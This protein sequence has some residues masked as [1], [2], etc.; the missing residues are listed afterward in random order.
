M[1]AI[2]FNGTRI[3]LVNSTENESSSASITQ[4]PVEEGMPFSDNMTWNGYSVQIT[5][6][7]L[8]DAAEESYNTLKEWQI[9]SELVSFRGRIYLKNA[10]IQDISKGYDRYENGFSI[11]ITLIPIRIASVFWEK[12]P[13]P[14]TVKQPEKSKQDEDKTATNET[15]VTVKAGDTYWG[16]WKQYG[17]AIQQL[18]DWNKWA[19]RQIPIGSRARVK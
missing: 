16:W 2:E 4:Y 8:G 6:Y 19:D 15:F 11:T 17:T 7:L 5:G 12:I 18:R 1:G 3:E 10:G 13:Q 14:P 9:S